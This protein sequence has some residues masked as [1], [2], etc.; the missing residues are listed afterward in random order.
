MMLKTL[1][2]FIMLLVLV[3][4]PA[5]CFPLE[6]TLLKA[7]KLALENNP[8]VRINSLELEIRQSEIKRK[9]AEYIPTL[10]L[11]SSYTYSKDDPDTSDLT[12]KNQNYQA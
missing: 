12:T 7:V 10:N 1:H 8:D 3:L 2:I 6:L 9:L 5:G 4:W 11:D